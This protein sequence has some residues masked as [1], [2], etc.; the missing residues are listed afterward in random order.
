MGWVYYMIPGSLEPMLVV[1]AHAL[2]PARCT[3]S[4]GVNLGSESRK[5][6][7]CPSDRLLTENKHCQIN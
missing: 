3:C 7:T 1:V 4:L 6:E 5:F 2:P